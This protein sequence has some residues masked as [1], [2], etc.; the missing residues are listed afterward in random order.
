MSVFFQRILVGL[1]VILV[2]LLVSTPSRAQA[3]KEVQELIK[4][5]VEASK[6]KDAKTALSY[7]NKAIKMNPKAAGLYLLRGDINHQMIKPKEAIA[8]YSKAVDLAP[9]AV[10]PYLRR[11]TLYQVIRKH[12]DA[13]TDWSKVIKL[14]PKLSQAYQA[15]GAERFKLGNFKGS[16]EDFDRYL[17]LKPKER[18]QHWMRGISLYYA[19]DYKEGKL[20]FEGY[21]T[22]DS[23]DVE[24]AVWRYLCM[25][26]VVGKKQA[27]ADML[28]IDGDDRIPMSQVYKMFA[29]KTEPED[30][31]KA[32][33]A[34]EPSKAQL[35]QRLFYAHLYIGLYYVSEGKTELGY[36]N[37]NLA[38]EN[39]PIGHYMWDVARVHRDVLKPKTK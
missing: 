34:G 6:N 3:N 11:A 14:A 26:P 16:V 2:T 29:G 25:V 1:G 15:R 27:Q 36:K 31:L 37:L 4:K 5:A 9:N 28:K 22:F 32:A 35:N 8:D 30:V 12:K 13:E 19:K 10:Q 24:N 21:Q 33:K 20:Q 17:K 23:T 38:T 39:Y 18:P 7:A